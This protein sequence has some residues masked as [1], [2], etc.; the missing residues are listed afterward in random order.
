MFRLSGQSGSQSQ[1]RGAATRQGWTLG[2]TVLGSVPRDTVGPVAQGSVVR[3][4]PLGAV[5]IGDGQWQVAERDGASGLPARGSAVNVGQLS[6]GTASPGLALSGHIGHIGH[7]SVPLQL[8]P[9]ELGSL[10]LQLAEREQQALLPAPGSSVQ[11]YN[12]P[13]AT[14]ASESLARAPAAATPVTTVEISAPYTAVLREA[15]KTPAPLAV[16]LSQEPATAVGEDARFVPRVQAMAASATPAAHRYLI[17]TNPA[18]TELTP[19]LSSDYL[20]GKLG[21]DPDQA[22][23]RLGDGLYEQRLIR[24]AITARIG[25][26]FL[27]GLHSDEAMFRHLMNNAIASKQALNLALGVSLSSEQVAALTH[28]IVWLEEHEV[29]GERVLVP[30]LYLAQANGRLAPNGALIQGRD[31]ALISGGE[32]NNQGT[33][34]ASGDLQLQAANITNSGVMQANERLQLLATDSIRNAQGGIIA[35]RDVSLTA[36]DGDILNERTVTATHSN[37]NDRTW[38]RSHIDSAAR[39]EASDH[40]SLAA[41]RDL[42]NLGGVLDSRS[43][44]AIQAGRDVNLASVQDVQHHSRGNWFLDERVTQLGGE[45]SAG[46]DLTI[47]AGRDLSVT[48][49]DLSAG[50]HLA[51]RAEH[52][53]TVASAADE[54]HAL[55]HTKRVTDQKDR[56]TQRAATLSAEGD[57]DISA[58]GDLAVIASRV[59][60]GEQAYLV[61]GGE[62]ALLAAQDSDY[63]LYQKK[64]KGSFGRNSFKRNETTDV[65]H[66]GSDIQAGGDLALLSGGD[67]TYQAARLESGADLTVSSAGQIAFEG[68]KD[69][70]Q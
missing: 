25:Q 3:I 5:A 61:A 69:L 4:D 28:D 63:A 24:E 45:V 62:L 60:A 31:V 10:P 12:P 29:A 41:G 18:L 66:V 38:I 2:Q 13:L 15:L 22:Q 9:L 68:V 44:L 50:R 55:W 39:I 52:D 16:A 27:A 54:S 32:L 70:E 64:K 43:D 7:A 56:V 11:L 36:R 34:R 47:S 46:R 37:L 17:E 53:L 51:L 58:G 57:L 21:F 20:L 48:A 59:T 8:D 23:K 42:S 30:V 26:R 65:T 40:L 33:L 35:G 67:Q 14:P 6:A 49:S 19:F 1:V